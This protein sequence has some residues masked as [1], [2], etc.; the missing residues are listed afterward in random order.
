M[1][2]RTSWKMV[3]ADGNVCDSGE[4]IEAEPPRKLVIRWRHQAKPELAAEGASLCT[5]ELEPSGTAAKLSI[6]HTIDR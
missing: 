1:D 2:A 3:Y 4:I 6:T 5:I